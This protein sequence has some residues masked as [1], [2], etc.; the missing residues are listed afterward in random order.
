VDDLDRFV[1]LLSDLFPDPADAP[2]QLRLARAFQRVLQGESVEA[3]SLETTFSR[4][5]LRTWTEAIRQGH[6]FRWVRRKPPTEERLLRA[7]AGI[8]QM[9][10][11]F[12]AEHHFE[13]S[14]EALLQSGGFRITDDRSDASDTDYRLLDTDDR[15]VCRL[16][17]KFHGTL[18]RAAKEYVGLEPDDCFALATYKIANALERQKE[19]A[20]PYA[21]LIVTVPS[22]P[23]SLVEG[24]IAE[25]H[26]WLASVT[27]RKVEE[28]IAIRLL[29]EPWAEELRAAVSKAEFRVISASRAHKLL[30]EKL[31]E[32]VFALRV[33]AFNWTFRG[34]EIDMHLSLQN[35][36]VLFSDF[37]QTITERGAREVAIRL[38]RG[39]I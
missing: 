12:L 6:F 22:L 18:F 15:P 24:H 9:M 39:E 25:E 31:F 13:Q 29:A 2:Q 8:A 14:S 33:R 4:S 19:E 30:H 26:S 34:A 27:G 21:F 10:L 3:V 37:V 23:R 17:I 20:V 32:R 16:N 11:G 7:R 38:D 35:E 36:M 1:S 5:Q 28:R